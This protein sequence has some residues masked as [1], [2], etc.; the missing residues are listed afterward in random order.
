MP[1]DDPMIPVMLPTSVVERMAGERGLGPGDW[2]WQIIRAARGA[3]PEKRVAIEI[4][5]S[6]RD[7]YADGQSRPG[8]PTSVRMAAHDDISDACRASRDAEGADHG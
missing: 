4:L 8:I 1:D 3:L 6:T 2:H 5:E 7:L